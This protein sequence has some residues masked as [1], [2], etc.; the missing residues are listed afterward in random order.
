MGF[1]ANCGAN[2]YIVNDQGNLQILKSNN[3]NDMVTVDN[4]ASL[5][6]AHMGQIIFKNNQLSLKDVLVVQHLKMNLFDISKRT[7]YNACLVEFNATGFIV[8]AQSHK[9]LASEDTRKKGFMP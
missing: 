2:T 5:P 9:V 6:I 1:F 3:W 8:K 7:S 4:E